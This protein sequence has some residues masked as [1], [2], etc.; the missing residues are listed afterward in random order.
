MNRTY[1]NADRTPISTE[2]PVFHNSYKADSVTL[3]GDAALKGEKT[4]TGRDM[5]RGE[6]FD[7]TLTAGDN[8]T[9]K[10]IER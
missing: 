6:T 8:A 9:E 1:L 3:T 4:L 5:M 2:V 7:F 10:A